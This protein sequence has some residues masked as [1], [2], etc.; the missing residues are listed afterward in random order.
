MLIFDSEILTK[1]KN[2]TPRPLFHSFSNNFMEFET[3]DFIGIRTRVIR[4]EDELADHWST[5][6]IAPSKT[7]LLNLSDIDCRV[8]R[9]SHVHHDVRLDD[10][11]ISSQT[12]DFH[13]GAGG[14][15]RE[16]A[17]GLTAVRH[18]AEIRPISK[19]ILSGSLIQ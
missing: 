14:P 12:I 4:A 16:V 18:E 17:E 1:M 13:E 2:L 5:T 11:M 15:V 3:I 10:V 9:L 8:E 6:T 7:L 19:L